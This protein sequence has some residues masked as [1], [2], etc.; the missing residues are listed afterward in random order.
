MFNL[1]KP[2]K[3]RITEEEK[4]AFLNDQLSNIVFDMLIE[5]PEIIKEYDKRNNSNIYTTLLLRGCDFSDMKIETREELE[6]VKKFAS[7]VTQ[8]HLFPKLENI[9]KNIY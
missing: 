9:A 4:I 5:K 8:N 3:K 7:F 2:F 6:A 1:F